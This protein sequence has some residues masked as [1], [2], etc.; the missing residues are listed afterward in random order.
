MI[1]FAI[2]PCFE[3]QDEA[4]KHN[5]LSRF[6]FDHT[7]Q[8]LVK[9]LGFSVHK[10]CQ[11][12]I[13]IFLVFCTR[14]SKAPITEWTRDNFYLA[15]MYLCCFALISLTVTPINE[16]LYCKYSTSFPWF[17]DDNCVTRH[18]AAFCRAFTAI[19][20]IV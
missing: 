12:F 18:T 7:Q 2:P 4:L 17:F 19:Y 14:Y 3:L 6:I 8:H 10:F 5:S 13:L 11:L 16:W 1:Q 15:I 9:R 20:S